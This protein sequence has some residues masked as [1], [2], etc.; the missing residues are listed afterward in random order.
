MDCIPSSWGSIPKARAMN[1]PA[2]NWG[3]LGRLWVLN[4]GVQTFQ[5]PP[6]LM[7]YPAKCRPS[8]GEYAAEMSFNDFA[9]LLH[10][11]GVMPYSDLQGHAAPTAATREIFDRA[12]RGTWPGNGKVRKTPFSSCQTH[13][14]NTWRTW[15]AKYITSCV[16]IWWFVWWSRSIKYWNNRLSWIFSIEIV[17][18][19]MMSGEHFKMTFVQGS[20]RMG[21]AEAHPLSRIR[22]NF[23]F[24]GVGADRTVDLGVSKDVN[25][26]H[27]ALLR[28]QTTKY[29]F[30][31]LTSVKTKPC[32]INTKIK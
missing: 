23:Y 12:R 26:N 8:G 1:Q 16:M 28:Q 27:L 31:E 24:W 5:I 2:T 29:N 4:Q 20:T 7:L 13:V 30:M 21:Y 19:C 18:F 3:W 15:V 9:H 14:G 10:R 17:I 25:F 22:P 6:L 11:C 32:E